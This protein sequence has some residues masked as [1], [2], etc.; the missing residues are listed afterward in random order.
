MS[1]IELLKNKL[2]ESRKNLSDSSINLYIRNLERL[3]NNTFKNL[4]F[5]KNYEDIELKLNNY[6]PNTKRTYLISIVSCLSLFKNEPKYKKI[7]KFYYDKME[8]KAKEIESQPKGEKTEK[9]KE[10]WVTLEEIYKK[11]DEMKENLKLDPKKIDKETYSKL[12][13]YL[14]LSL[15]IL[16]N[17]R[18]NMDYIEMNVISEF[19]DTMSKDKNYLDLSK[20]E[21]KFLKHKTS[22]KYKEQ[23]IKISEKLLD[24]IKLYLKYHPL[25]KSKK[26]IDVP[27][28]VY[29]DGTPIKQGNFITKTLNRIFGK[30]IGSSM[31]RHIIVSEKFSDVIK[32][33]KETAKNMGHTLETQ[34]NDYIKQ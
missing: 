2:K 20:D 27:F 1:F 14:I 5:L 22:K 30:K 16:N 3:N 17:P 26:N 13:D 11:L 18:R 25:I 12:L 28:L 24:V 34:I 21:F 19:K 7:Y 6:K 31:L 33:M 23:D 8:S 15:Y 4:M 10:N 9:Q 29:Y 32:D